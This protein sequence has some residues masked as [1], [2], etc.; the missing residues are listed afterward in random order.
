MS[1]RVVTEKPI[2]TDAQ[3][4][5]NL[6]LANNT[7]AMSPGPLQSKCD[8]YD[9]DATVWCFVL[10]INGDFDMSDM[11]LISMVCLCVHVLV[12]L[13]MSGQSAFHSVSLSTRTH[14]LMMLIGGIR[15]A[16]RQ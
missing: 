10:N 12:C 7:L 16:C 6:K 14:Q 1:Q 3:Q 5:G 8:S 13:P 15:K 11:R 9:Y 4:H 2:P